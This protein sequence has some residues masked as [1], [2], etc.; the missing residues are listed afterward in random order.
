M[1]SSQHGK[2]WPPN[3]QSV[4]ESGDLRTCL[5]QVGFSQAILGRFGVREVNMQA[6]RAG[7]AG[8]GGV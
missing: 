7:R 6:V 4:I 3:L 5:C 2:Q 8:V 1:K